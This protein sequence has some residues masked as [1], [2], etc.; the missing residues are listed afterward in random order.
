MSYNNPYNMNIRNQVL[1]LDQ[2]FINRSNSYDLNNGEL[3]FVDGVNTENMTSN[4]GG[5][6]NMSGYAAGTFRDTGYGSVLGAGMSGMAKHCKGG[7]VNFMPMPYPRNPPRDDVKR[8]VGGAILGGEVNDVARKRRTKKVES[9]LK[10]EPGLGA[11]KSGGKLIPKEEMKGSTMSGGE[12]KRGRPSKMSGGFKVGDLF[13]SDFWNNIRIESGSGKSAAGKS[14][15]VKCK[16]CNCDICEC[17]KGKGKSGGVKCK[18]CNCDVCKCKMGK[19]MSGGKS[20]RAEIVKKI[21]NDKNI[22]MIEASK[23][24]KEHNLY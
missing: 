16:V 22:S 18:V 24:V 21:M 12:K 15:G 4:N 13:T 10:A 11:G 8:V 3:S 5:E 7:A 17:K 9:E 20:K 14:G 19:G 1:A 2:D 6:P 23:Y